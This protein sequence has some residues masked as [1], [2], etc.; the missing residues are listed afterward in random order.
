MAMTSEAKKS[1][2][3][4]EEMAGW[5]IGWIA[6]EVGMPSEEIDTGRSLLQ[7]SLSSVT[8]TILVGDLEDWLELRLPPTLVW[9]YPSI[10][11][12]THYLY[13]KATDEALPP[14]SA[15]AGDPAT[16]MTRSADQTQDALQLLEGLDQLSDEEVDAL[17]N[18]FASSEHGGA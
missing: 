16:V 12:M 3:T 11:A 14:F 9:D 1:I 2:P 13:E 10:D 17:L 7:Y 6:K 18:R 4:R 8:A 15:P 5:L